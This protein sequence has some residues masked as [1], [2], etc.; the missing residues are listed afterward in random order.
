MALTSSNTPADS[1]DDQPPQRRGLFYGWWIVIVGMLSF[2]LASGANF[3]GFGVFIK[4]FERE[5]GWNRT[6]VSA[7]FSLAR[8]EVGMFGPLEGWA[9]DKFGPRRIMLI[10]IPLMGLGYIAMSR[11]NSLLAVLTAYAFGIALGAGLGLGTPVTVAVANW[12]I[13]RRGL[14]FG[15]LWSGVGLGGVILPGIGWLVDSY[16]WRD[17]AVIIGLVII[18]ISV[19]VASVVRHRP[20]P[21]GY[22]PDGDLF[23]DGS[24]RRTAL[25][26]TFTSA[27]FT[28]RDA[29]RTASFWYI[30]VSI[31]V[32]TFAS[33]GTSLALV[34][35][36]IEMGEEPVRAAALA[37]SVG[38][39]SIP[40]RFG[41]SVLSDYMNRRYLMAILL[42]TMAVGM[43]LLTRISTAQAAL[44]V[45]F[46]YAVSQG[47]L[48]SIPQ[49]LVAD[50]FGRRA[51]GVIHGF[52]AMVQ[53][54]GSVMGPVLAGYI[55]DQTGS[56]E[57]AFITFAVTTAMSIVLILLAVPPTPRSEPR[58]APGT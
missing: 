16:G 13:R 52:R 20:E 23:S 44:P 6:T 29:L 48:A 49:S 51:F 10:G 1:E 45:L 25:R 3:Q 9:V 22:L 12:F 37:G 7:V 36:F 42:A 33:A 38:I 31:G 47:G 57:R 39:M 2:G 32:R 35:F 5:F 58:T 14:A 46:L 27:D 28:A 18:A 11:S 34:P 19:P 55:Y 30:S 41:M 17:A 4:P 54:L 26:T 24:S 8:L 50:Y 15:I 40:G 43:F 21:Y 53:T 56:Y